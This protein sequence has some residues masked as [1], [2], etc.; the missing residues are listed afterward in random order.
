MQREKEIELLLDREKIPYRKNEP[1]K[2]HT[3]FHIGGDAAFFIT[4]RTQEELQKTVRLLTPLAPI[5]F[6]GRG[7]NLLVSDAGLDAVVVEIGKDFSQITFPEE[8]TILASAGASLLRLCIEAKDRG[9]TGLEFAYGIPGSVGGAVYM[10]AGAFSGEMK[11]VVEYVEYLDEDGVLRRVDGAA[12]DFGYRKSFFT[13]KNFCILQAK[14]RLR[15]GNREEIEKKM[16]ELMARRKLKQPLEY[17]SAGSTFKR[18]EGAYAGAL[19]EQ[20]G[21]KGRSVGGAMVSEKHA[22]FL[23]NYQNATC[24]DMRSLI[25]L[26]QEEVKEKTGYQLECE[27]LFLGE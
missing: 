9:L 18:P 25:R 21:L 6:L 15:K 16:E 3:S 22:N 12:L 14:I 23:I 7:S 10:N 19:I 11:D 17:P 13:G 20:S 24:A 8:E 5:F 4:P 1:M 26:V 27:V 2:E